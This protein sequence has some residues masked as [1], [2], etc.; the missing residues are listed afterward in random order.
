MSEQA[1]VEYITV[2]AKLPVA[3]GVASACPNCGSE[4]TLGRE[5]DLAESLGLPPE[6]ELLGC[7]ECGWLCV[8][9]R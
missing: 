3:A 5:P 9:R 8:A 4:G 2:E 7:S 6:L 1:A